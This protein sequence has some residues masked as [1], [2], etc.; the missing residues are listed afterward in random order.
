VDMLTV[1]L[2]EFKSLNCGFISNGIYWHV[3]RHIQFHQNPSQS[4]SPEDWTSSGAVSASPVPLLRTWQN[5]MHLGL[6]AEPY[7]PDLKCGGM[8]VKSHS[9]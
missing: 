7:D 9:V 1:R 5:S 8:G 6:V 4:D 3:G 2:R